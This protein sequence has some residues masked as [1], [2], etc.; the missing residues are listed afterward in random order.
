MDDKKVFFDFIRDEFAPRLREIG[1]KGSGNHFRRINEEIIHCI[2]IQGSKYGK[3]CALNMGVHLTFL[4]TTHNGSLP[5]LKKIKQI[6]CELF[7]RLSPK[8]KSDYWWKYKSFL[9]GPQKQAGHL[10]KTFFKYGEPCFQKY[11]TVSNLVE[12][13]KHCDLESGVYPK[14]DFLFP[15]ELRGARFLAYIYQHLG[16]FASAHKYVKYGLAN[17]ELGLGLKE[18]FEQLDANLKSKL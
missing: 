16:D 12:L 11:S 3:S 9:R 14:S 6:D 1:F 2:N 13:Y 5:D 7:R 8:M 15:I 10:I 18:E 17:I 4:P